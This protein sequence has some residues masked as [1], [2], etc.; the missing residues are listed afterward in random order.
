VFRY[1]DMNDDLDIRPIGYVHSVL[2][3]RSMAPR[4]GSEGAPDARLEI[5]PAF[6]AGREG[7]EA[8]IEIWIFTWFHQSERSVLRVHPRGDARKEMR[9]VFST[10]SPDRPNP[11]GLHRARVLKVDENGSLEVEG[12][13]AINGTPIVDIKPVIE[14]RRDG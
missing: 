8:G 6:V 5:L 12:L 7:I 11:L 9:G 4:Q 3:D 2:K 10:R 1:F 13:E 14:C